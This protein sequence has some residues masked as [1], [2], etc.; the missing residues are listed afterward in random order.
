MAADN[1]RLQ[2]VD[3]P[4]LE[5]WLKELYAPALPP[6]V[7]KTPQMQ[8]RLSTLLRLH[9]PI[10]EVQHIVDAVQ[11]EATR[12]YTALSA[13]ISD[14]LQAANITLSS[15]PSSTS[16]AL[17]ELSTTAVDLGLSDM[18]AE[19]FEC[20]VASQTMQQFKRQ[21]EIDSLNEQTTG[22][23][24]K[25]RS[26]QNRQ[27]KLRALLE[28]RRKAA[29][30]E[31]QKAREWE[32]NAQVVSQKS[33]EYR[34]RLA[35]LQ[36]AV[37]ESGAEERGLDYDQLKELDTRVEELRATVDK[38]QNIYK[39]YE[40]LPPDISLAYVKLEEAKVKLEQLRAECEHAVDAA[41]STRK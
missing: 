24:Q 20:A 16:K 10:L 8:H 12:E 41:F 30:I 34:E 27:A 17:S 2:S 33:N 26:S 31:E 37:K 13:T 14:N 6:M 28:D 3:W 22:L 9:Q 29:P 7:T 36:R 40:A 21:T 15:L 35:E 18:R 23:Q 19:S 39:G 25:I 38:K 11:T 4:A 32:R 1:T 5:Q